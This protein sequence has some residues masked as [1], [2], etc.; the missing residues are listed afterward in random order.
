MDIFFNIKNDIP[1]MKIIQ[2]FY[3][4][5]I[6]FIL[7]IKKYILKLKIDCEKNLF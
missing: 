1:S 3:V 6:Y 7:F 2:T 4:I 5:I